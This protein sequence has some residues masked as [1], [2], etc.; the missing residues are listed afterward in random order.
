MKQMIS[1]SRG[2]FRGLVMAGLIGVASLFQGCATGTPPE[3]V[4]FVDVERYTGLWY[5]IASYPQ[6]FNRGL[7]NTTA[8][9]A[10]VDE[11]KI[12]VLNKANEGPGGPETS[13]SGFAFVTDKESNAKLR[14]SFSPIFPRLF[15]GQYWII[16]LDTEGYTWAVVSNARKSSLFIL[17]RTPEM[18]EELFEG[19]VD[20]LVERGFDRDRLNITPQGV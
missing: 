11:G 14:V 10:I 18:D 17:S 13:I 15:A 3:T 20:D 19:L 1:G 6:F 12:S 16:A 9:Y 2:M 8:E 7:V 4:S 5:E